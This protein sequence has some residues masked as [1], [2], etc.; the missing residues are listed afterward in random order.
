MLNWEAK[1]FHLY[2]PFCLIFMMETTVSRFLIG[3]MERIL[4][5]H[6]LTWKTEHP[7][8]PILD[9][10]NLHLHSLHCSQTLILSRSKRIVEFKI[11]TETKLNSGCI[12]L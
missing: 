1:V 6:L 10:I 8:T 4:S 7:P 3:Q 2:Q 12:Y 5:P 11:E 9:V